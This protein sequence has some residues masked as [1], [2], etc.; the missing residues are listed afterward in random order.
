QK[1]RTVPLEGRSRVSQDAALHDKSQRGTPLERGGR[2]AVIDA[3]RSVDRLA[4][5]RDGPEAR[6]ARITVARA[7][8]GAPHAQCERPVAL[9]LV[10]TV[11]ARASGEALGDVS[12]DEAQPSELVLSVV[13]ERLPPGDLA[14]T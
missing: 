9:R 2:L 5:G 11:L 14:G 1:R 10:A 3:L 13:A 8:V 6:A 7:H 4:D 12:S